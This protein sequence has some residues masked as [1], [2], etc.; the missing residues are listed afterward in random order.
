MCA[1]VDVNVASEVFGSPRPPAGQVFFEWLESPRGQLVVGGR[2][3]DELNHNARLLGWLKSATRFGRVRLVSDDEVDDRAK[4]LRREGICTSNDE[5]VLA[6]ALVSGAR[7]LYTNDNALIADFKNRA[8]VAGP[9][10]RIYTTARSVAV[11]SA[12]LGL[13]AAPD[14]CRPSR[15]LPGRGARGPS[16]TR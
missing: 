7:L 3:R 10:G 2:L 16:R 1:I 13:L 8:I 11:T 6:L 14:L 5:H 15:E 12:H 9:R 4:R